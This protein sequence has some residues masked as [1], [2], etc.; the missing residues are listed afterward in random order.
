MPHWTQEGVAPVT[1]LVLNASYEPLVV[2]SWKRAITLVLA[3]RAEV[4]EHHENQVIRSAGGLEFPMPHVVRLMTMVRFSGM[5]DRSEPRFSKIGLHH[6]D[7][8]MCQVAGCA[9]RGTTTDHLIPRS[10]G[11]ETS[12][13]NCVLMCQRHNSHKGDRSLEDL[14]WN[15]KRRPTVPCRVVMTPPGARPEWA[16][17]LS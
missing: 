1:V 9:E 10:R 8:C 11:G 6:R 2:V 14:N 12:W 16:R 4:V 13:E 7:G 15:L 17:W 5:R 3:E